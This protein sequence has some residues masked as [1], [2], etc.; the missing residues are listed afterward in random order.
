MKKKILFI[1][2]CC[3]LLF[4]GVVSAASLWG[5]YKGNQIIRLT[6][7]GSQIK[8]SDVPAISFNGRTM[9]PIY[10]LNQAG[11]NYTW[12][13]KNQTVDIVSVNN[14]SSGNQTAIKQHINTAD[15]FQSLSNLGDII[16]SLSNG[17]SLAYDGIKLS[18]NPQA[19]FD[20]INKQLNEVIDLYNQYNNTLGSNPKYS[21]IL[22]S[23]REALENFKVVDTSL[24]NFYL[25]KK[26]S[27]FDNYLNY[28][29]SAF[30]KSVI[31]KYEAGKQYK[32]YINLA[33][34]S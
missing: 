33:K 16:S 11:I 20:E 31:T 9:I 22:N 5:T 10:L 2:M 14:F 30:Q 25:Y 8:V 32:Y 12:D 27:D 34:N 18:N 24:Y 1:A 28:K 19:H 6:I 21:S 26:Q 4:S 17:Y 13:A 23:Y 3:L 29:D 7:N 15:D